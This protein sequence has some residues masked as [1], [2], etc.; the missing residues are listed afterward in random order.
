MNF[1]FVTFKQIAAL[2]KDNAISLFKVV[3]AFLLP[4]KP[5]IV[6]M[7]MMIALDTVTG[8]IKARKLKD[9]ITSRKLSAVVGKIVLYCLGIIA[10]Y[11]LDRY[12]LGEFVN[13]FTNIK[14]FLTKVTTIFCWL[15]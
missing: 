7:V 13:G 8:L 3:G 11:A 5:L 12:L 6:L 9:K 10:I 1:L 15:P 4:I 14:L 2:F